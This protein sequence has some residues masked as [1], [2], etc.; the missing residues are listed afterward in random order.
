M[1]DA[2]NI[3]AWIALAMGLYAIAAGAG[4]LG[5]PDKWRRMALELDKSAALGFLTGIMTFAL[6]TAIFL[7]TPRQGDWLTILVQILGAG[8]A[9]EG[10]MFLAL[11]KFMG[12]FARA[13]LDGDRLNR[14]WA[15]LSILIGVALCFIGVRH[16]QLPH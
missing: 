1:A 16:L 13:L 7:L 12:R 2:S 4:L 5:A 9:I 11:P 14:L 15:W 10:L 8:M 6:G 3:A